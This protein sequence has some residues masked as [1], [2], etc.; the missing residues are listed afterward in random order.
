MKDFSHRRTQ[1]LN[2]YLDEFQQAVEA[3]FCINKVAR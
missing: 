3:C 1:I 2:I